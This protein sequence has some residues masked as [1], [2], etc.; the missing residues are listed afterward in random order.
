MSTYTRRDFTKF[1]LAAG[2]LAAS[3]RS[4]FAAA[5]VNSKVNGVQIGLN[6]PY[7]F[8]TP[9]ITGDEILANCVKLGLSGVELRAQSVEVFLGAPSE[10]VFAR[11]AVATGGAT[12]GGAS[13]LAEWRK[14]AA[15]A[16]AA[17]YRKKF[18]DAGV[19]IEVVKVDNIFKFSDAEIDYAFTLAKT[20]GARAISTEISKSDEEHKRLGTFADKHKFLVGLH[21]HHT[22][23]MEHF[24]HAFGDSKFLGVNLDIGHYVGGGNGSPIPFLKKHHARIS[25]LHIKDRKIGT[26]AKVGD[27]VPFGE[28]DTPIKEALHLIRDNKWP[29]QAT[30]EFEYK[31]PAGSDRMTEIAK[32]VQYCRDALA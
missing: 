30:I 5:A 23:N 4:L 29:I 11:P 28:G 22:S 10:L 6:V 31:V 18:N 12:P 1:A 19:A 17:D 7:S 9:T 8:G 32:C 14:T 20:L 25:H 2:A 26:A 21:G 24:E 15:V 27:N 13:K 16:K 3:S